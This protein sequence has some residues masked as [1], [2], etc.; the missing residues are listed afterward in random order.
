MTLALW[1]ICTALDFR[2]VT[3]FNLWW[4]WMRWSSINTCCMFF[5]ILLTFLMQYET[6]QV[7]TQISYLSACVTS[8]FKDFERAIYIWQTDMAEWYG[9]LY[10]CGNFQVLWIFGF[11]D[12][13]KYCWSWNKLG[14][15]V[16]RQAHF[17]WGIC[18]VMFSHFHWVLTLILLQ[19]KMVC[20]F[21]SYF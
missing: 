11:S 13:L 14:L 19:F 6:S 2:K 16:V 3:D 12:Y 1:F 8:D 5:D 15:L 20:M 9:T 17:L 4:K 7:S 18:F 10:Q 21:Y